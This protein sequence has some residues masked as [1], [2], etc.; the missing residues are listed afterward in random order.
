MSELDPA[1]Y[2]LPR[3]DR[4]TSRSILSGVSP[5]REYVFA[6]YT[7]QPRAGISLPDAVG[8]CQSG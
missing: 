5:G 4:E 6:D 3:I 7:V 8:T 2:F 1:T